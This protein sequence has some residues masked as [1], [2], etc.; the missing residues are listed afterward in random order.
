MKKPILTIIIFLSL[1]TVYGQSGLN[2]G[3]L[4]LLQKDTKNISINSFEKEKINELKCFPVKDFVFLK[5]KNHIL[6]QQTSIKIIHLMQGSIHQ[7]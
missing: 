4:F 6:N 7:K 2:N 3:S 5:L 1:L